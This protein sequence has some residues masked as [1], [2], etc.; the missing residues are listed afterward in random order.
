MA[1][2]PERP[3]SPA[4]ELTPADEPLAPG[5]AVP[6]IDP[7]EYRRVL[8]HFPTG[9]TVVTALTDAGPVGLS[10]GSFTS[11]SLDP[12]LIGFLPA[13][14]SQSWPQIEAVGRFC[15]NVLGSDQEELA[16]LFAAPHDDRFDAVRWQPAPVSGAPVL[17]GVTAWVDCE[18]EGVLP[19]GDHHFVL[20]R[21]RALGADRP[22]DEPLVFFRGAYRTLTR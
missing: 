2:V 3:A 7:A 12:P 9:V 13:R 4:D 5:A 20:G 21:V 22:G 14:A 8:G 6:E 16:R 17:A 18:L 15:V 11:V 10:I 19:A 1:H